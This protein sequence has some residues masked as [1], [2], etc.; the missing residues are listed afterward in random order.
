MDDIEAITRVKNGDVE[1]FAI[2]VEKYHR[3][4]LAFIHRLVNDN[5][6]VEDIGQEV[7]LN[8]Y[9]SLHRFDEQAGVPFSAWLFIIARNRVLSELRKKGRRSMIGLEMLTDSPDERPTALEQMTNN[10][11]L[12]ALQDSLAQLPEPYRNTILK[13]LQ[14]DSIAEIARLEG[15]STGTVKS[16]ISRAKT[17]LKQLIQEYFGGRDY[18]EI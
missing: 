8:T 1:A 11:Q 10:E 7:F 18:G 14:G 4:L 17:K 9:K 13:S 15:I 2:L 6:V 16:R 3:R 12:Q 5:S